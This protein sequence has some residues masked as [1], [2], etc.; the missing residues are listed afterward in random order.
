MYAALW[1]NHDGFFPFW[2]SKNHIWVFM[3]SLHYVAT[4][5][6]HV[7]MAMCLC[8]CLGHG[9]RKGK[10]YVSPSIVGVRDS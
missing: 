10:M 8:S 5:G 7:L 2:L 3:F 9:R 6:V 1:A 4:L